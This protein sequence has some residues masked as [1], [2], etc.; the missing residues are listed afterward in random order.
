MTTYDQLTEWAGLGH[1]TRAG[2]DVVVG[3]RIPDSMKAQLVEVGIPIA[4]RLIERVVMQSEAKPALLTSCGRVGRVG[5]GDGPLD[6]QRD[7]PN[8]LV[9]A[10]VPLRGARS[11]MPD[12]GA[13][14]TPDPSPELP[15]EHGSV[16]HDALSRNPP[17]CRSGGSGAVCCRATG[18]LDL[19][20][21]ECRQLRC[22]ST[23]APD[24][25]RTRRAGC[26]RPRWLQPRRPGRTV[27]HR[28]GNPRAHWS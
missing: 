3:W 25:R 5:H 24:G 11:L 19:V 9:Y 27:R 12:A 4:P 21:D 28:C 18:L 17:A 26:R 23:P 6:G 20:L 15:A 2:R 22:G 10:T 13:A 1:V 14:R 7:S 16:G 8:G